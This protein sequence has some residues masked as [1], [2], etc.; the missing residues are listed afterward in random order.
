VIQESVFLRHR[1]Q[2]CGFQAGRGK[3][4]D[5]GEFGESGYKLLHLEWI[6]HEVLLCSIGNN[7]QSLGINMLEDNIRKGMYV[8]V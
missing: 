7:I 3:E 8:Y 4:W 5:G 6:S 1:E 2:T